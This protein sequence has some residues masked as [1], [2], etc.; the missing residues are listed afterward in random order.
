MLSW[1]IQ[2]SFMSIWTYFSRIIL[3]QP[4]RP[5]MVLHMCIY[6]VTHVREFKTIFKSHHLPLPH[7]NGHPV[8]FSP[9][10]QVHFNCPSWDIVS[11][12]LNLFFSFQFLDSLIHSSNSTYLS[13][14]QIKTFPSSK[15]S[16]V[17]PCLPNKILICRYMPSR[18]AYCS[19]TC[20]LVTPI[21]SKNFYIFYLLSFSLLNLEE[22]FPVSQSIV[23]SSEAVI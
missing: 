11:D 7:P 10:S 1:F 17:S 2:F 5:L 22:L 16:L 20:W 12:P 8:L 18:D 9:F 13:T 6:Q 19:H 14:A 15:S 4:G 23:F 3:P 21:T